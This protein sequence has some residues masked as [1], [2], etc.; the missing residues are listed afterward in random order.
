VEIIYLSHAVTRMQERNISVE[1][2]AS[3]IEDPEG[4]IKQSKDKYIYYKKVEKR[5]DNMIAIVLLKSK[6]KELEVLTVMINFE[7]K[8]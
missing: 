8:G 6:S 7:V 5:K 4:V 1:E 3:I 2:V